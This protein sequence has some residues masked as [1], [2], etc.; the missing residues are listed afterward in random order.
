VGYVA[1]WRRKCTLISLIGF[2]R[3]FGIALGYAGGLF[4]GAI[5]GALTGQLF[6]V[7]RWWV[8]PLYKVYLPWLGL[9]LFIHVIG[10]TMK[11]YANALSTRVK[12]IT[13]ELEWLAKRAKFDE[14]DDVRC[15]V[16]VPVRVWRLHGWRMVQASDYV[17]NVSG[18]D[19]EFYR[20]SKAGRIMSV[21]RKGDEGAELPVGVIGKCLLYFESGKPKIATAYVRPGEKF[22]EAMVNRYNYTA[23]E[24]RRLRQDR[25]DYLAFPITTRDERT[26]LGILHCDSGNFGAL[27][28]YK[29]RLQRDLPHLAEVLTL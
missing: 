8:W 15:V 25:L 2:L 20:N 5:A 26:L 28:T 11:I 1:S 6:D 4:A 10:A 9:S 14:E 3:V 27:A 23:K 19:R 17:P 18:V 12:Y 7:G 22:V 13:C 24:A 21:R 16:W 29:N